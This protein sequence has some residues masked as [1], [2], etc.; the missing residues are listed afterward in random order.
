MSHQQTV[1]RRFTLLA[2][3]TSDRA[4]MPVLKWLWEQHRPD[5]L[6]T[7]DFADLEYS[8]LSKRTLE[9]RLPPTLEL[10]PCDLLFIHRDA[11]REGREKRISEIRAALT[12]SIGAPPT[13]CVVPVRM[14]EAWM[15]FNETAIRKAAGNPRGTIKLNLPATSKV[16][17]L[18]D[19]K[20]ILHELLK[21]AADLPAQRLRRFNVKSAAALVTEY[22]E[23]FSALR[24]LPAFVEMEAEFKQVR[25]DLA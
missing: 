16:E 1:I 4:L 2:E 17:K 18:P 13:I 9:V 23:D 5:E 22:I 21:T 7:G 14:S 25:F 20:V 12:K 6:Y 15:L 24:Q 11:D 19:P 3:G 10:Y 8:G